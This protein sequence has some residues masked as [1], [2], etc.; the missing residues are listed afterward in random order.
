MLTGCISRPLPPETAG[1]SL[2]S[3]SSVSVGVYKPGFLVRDGQI[4]LRGY[5]CKQFNG[6]S[7]KN[8]HLDIVYLNRVERKISVEIAFFQPA[9]LCYHLRM[10]QFAGYYEIPLLKIPPGTTQIQVRAHDG[11][12]HGA[13]NS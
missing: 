3:I 9:E 10:P 13:S 2:T 12:H 1:L 7:T 4:T 6:P 8:T 11:P 5:V